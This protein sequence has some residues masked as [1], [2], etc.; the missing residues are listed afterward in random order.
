M[1]RF[2]VWAP[3]AR[4]VT[5]VADDRTYGM[6]PSHGNDGWWRADVPAAGPGSDYGFRLDDD[7]TVLPD[8][9]SRWQ[10]S[11]VHGP[12]RLYDDASFAWTDSGWRGVQ[13][14]GSVF[15]ELHVGT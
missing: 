8:P 1:T 2:E 10:P 15:Y 7:E 3:H 6:N 11:G 12:S 14:P 5:V 13:L 9:R 4:T